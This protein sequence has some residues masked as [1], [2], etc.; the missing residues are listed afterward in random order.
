MSN[1]HS[2]FKML[3]LIVAK[4]DEFIST[5]VIKCAGSRTAKV[6]IEKEK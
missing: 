5:E 4:L 6:T 1:I 2:D 3:R